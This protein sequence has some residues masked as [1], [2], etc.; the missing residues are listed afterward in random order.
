MVPWCDDCNGRRRTDLSDITVSISITCF[1]SDFP[2]I[3][4]L[5]ICTLLNLCRFAVQSRQ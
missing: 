1:S 2:G 5:H 3:S 4:Y